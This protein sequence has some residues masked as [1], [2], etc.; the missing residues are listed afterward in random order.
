MI[1]SIFFDVIYKR[2]EDFM[3]SL[4][5]VSY[6]IVSNHRTTNFNIID[7]IIGMLFVILLIYI[8]KKFRDFMNK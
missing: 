7:L 6:P 1:G 5:Y 2:K 8:L 3:I 4:Y